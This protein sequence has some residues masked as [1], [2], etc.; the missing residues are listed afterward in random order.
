MREFYNRRG[1][2]TCSLMLAEWLAAVRSY[3]GCVAA[4]PREFSL[5]PYV[6]HLDLL[7]P[8]LLL[9]PRTGAWMSESR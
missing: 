5:E 7:L 1:L 8:L 3:T 9:W 6:A 4:K 2:Q